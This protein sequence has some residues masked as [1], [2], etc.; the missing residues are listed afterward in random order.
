MDRVD[1]EG[2]QIAFERAGSGPAVVLVHGFVGDGPSTWGAQIEVLS[3]DFTVVAWDG[4]GAGAS[5]DPPEW[6]RAADYADCLVAFLRAIGISQAHVVGLSFGGIVALSL[7][8]RHPEVPHSLGLL[9]AYA[10]WGGSLPCDEVDTRLRRCLELSELPAEEF[11]DELVPSMFSAN[12][13]GSVVA[14]FAASVRRRH[15]TGFR[16][17]ALASAAA[18]LR[19]VLPEVSVATLLVYGDLDVRAPLDVA[20]RIRSAVPAARM[21][22]LPGVGHACSVEAP[23]AV[24]RELGDFLRSVEAGHAGAAG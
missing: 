6:F 24:N 13:D 22:V 4:P 12:A 14:E 16:I 21:V 8:E 17:M 9:S 15:P 19:H 10:G 18:D 7:F 3:E 2:L 1:V 5:S 11:A 20:E 23:E